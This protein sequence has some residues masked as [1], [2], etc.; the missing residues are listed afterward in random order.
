[1]FAMAMIMNLVLHN[2]AKHIEIQYHFIQELMEKKEIKLEFCKTREQLANIF[3]KLILI[4]KYN[5][6]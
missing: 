3:T 5:K 2:C 1:M 4:K 6:F